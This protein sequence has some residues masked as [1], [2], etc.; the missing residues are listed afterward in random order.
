MDLLHVREDM[1]RRDALVLA[2]GLRALEVLGHA[3]RQVLAQDVRVELAP[4]GGLELALRAL[5]V[6]ELQVLTLLVLVPD[7]LHQTSFF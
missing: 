5:L 4:V 6:L 1:V 3:G 2:A 7:D